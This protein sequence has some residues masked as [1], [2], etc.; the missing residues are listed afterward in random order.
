MVQDASRWTPWG[1]QYEATAR[2]FYGSW[3]QQIREV[4]ERN[5]MFV[6]SLNVV[7]AAPRR[8]VIPPALPTNPPH[9]GAVVR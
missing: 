8:I 9:A 6:R 5:R 4:H 7:L 2:R 3:Y 1:E